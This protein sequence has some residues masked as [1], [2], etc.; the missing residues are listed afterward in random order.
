MENG[1]TYHFEEAVNVLRAIEGEELKRYNKAID[2]EDLEEATAV[3]VDARTKILKLRKWVESLQTI[4][5]EIVAMFPIDPKHTVLDKKPDDNSI[6]V[7]INNSNNGGESDDTT[8]KNTKNIPNTEPL[9]DGV[10]PTD[11][12]FLG[13]SY[14]ISGISD[15]I[16]SFCEILILNRP[17]KFARMGGNRA[18]DKNGQ[19]ILSLNKQEIKEPH[20]KLS[21]GFF[22]NT[23]GSMSDIRAQCDLML[24]ECGYSAE[25]L[26]IR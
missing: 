12:E 16:T 11:F 22:I 9:S 7:G 21:N 15:L 5:G 8:K 25:T 20:R 18:T 4:N 10:V 23:D 6:Q 26:K 2:I 13:D 14:T 24:V 17:Y 19:L 1:Y 3:T